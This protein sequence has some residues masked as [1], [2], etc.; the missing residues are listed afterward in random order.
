MEAMIDRA[1]ADI[2][3]LTS[4]PTAPLVVAD[5]DEVLLLLM[6]ALLDGV[7]LDRFVSGMT[8]VLRIAMFFGSEGKNIEN[9]FVRCFEHKSVP[10]VY[11][12]TFAH[13]E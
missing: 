3:L 6:G 4:C 13:N 1:V 7:T 8:E 11:N 9:F 10:E 2:G 5:E 12:K